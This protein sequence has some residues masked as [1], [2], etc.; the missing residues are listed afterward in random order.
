MSKKHEISRISLS[1]SA[2]LDRCKRTA[3]KYWRVV[4]KIVGAKPLRQ[5]NHLVVTPPQN[6]IHELQLGTCHSPVELKEVAEVLSIGDRIRVFCDDGVVLAEKISP[7]Q[8][9]LIDCQMLPES[10]H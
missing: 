6:A 8:F 1:M 3:S 10:V 2:V 7:T 4:S 9:K 5:Q